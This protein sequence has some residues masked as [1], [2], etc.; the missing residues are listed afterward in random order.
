MATVKISE[1]PLADTPLGGADVFP[2]VQDGTTKRA[3]VSSAGG[4]SSAIFNVRDYGALGNGSAD[5]SPA[6][7]LAIADAIAAGGGIVYVPGGTYRISSVQILGNNV[8]VAGDSV[9]V[10]QIVNGSTNSYALR[11]GDGTTQYYGGGLR[12]IKFGGASG[13]TGVSGQSGVVFYKIGQ[14]AVANVMVIPYP[15]A[16]YKGAR[17]VDCSQFPVY[18]LQVQDCLNHGVE[19]T[20]TTDAYVTDCRSDANGDSGFYFN[21]TQGSYVKGCSAWNNTAYGWL[22][23]SST[24][25]SFSNTNNF[26]VSC[27]GD[28][29]GSYNWLIND[30]VNSYWTACW[31]ASQQSTSVNTGAAGFIITTQYS[32]NLFF[33]GCTASN[34]NSHGFHVYDSGSSAP[35]SIHFVNCQF[36][37]NSYTA[38]GNGQSGAGYGLAY[39]G[40]ID[41]LRVVGGAFTNNASGPVSNLIPTLDVVFRDAVGFKT[42]ANGTAKITAGNTSVVVTHG[43]AVTP[44]SQDISLTFAGPASGAAGMYVDTITSTQFTIHIASAVGADV[45]INW[46]AR[47][48]G[49]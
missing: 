40:T 21:A 20:R 16:L 12:D 6:F 31:G 30:S 13:V 45:D 35:S 44:K 15:S 23:S 8:L 7:K 11:W 4:R 32:K 2:L 25:S 41:K 10:S 17:F 29:S 3:Y 5:D 28:T 9:G 36:G 47:S 18:N 24:P 19:F 42:A 37:A 26:F 34:N 43:L 49:P 27:V 38:S 1:L 22:F 48:L 33:T 46:I 39:D 14:F